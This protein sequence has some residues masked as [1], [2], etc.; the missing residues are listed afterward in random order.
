MIL[1]ADFQFQSLRLT[2]FALAFFLSMICHFFSSLM[3]SLI[4]Y[5]FPAMRLFSQAAHRFAILISFSLRRDYLLLLAIFSSRC[6]AAAVC[7]RYACRC[8]H[9]LLL[10]A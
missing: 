1:S 7:F 4:A 5:Y 8:L 2:A 10:M 6:Q 3:I 9:F